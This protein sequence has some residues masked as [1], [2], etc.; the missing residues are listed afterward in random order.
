M[1][2]TA[3]EPDVNVDVETNNDEDDDVDVNPTGSDGDDDD[4]DKESSEDEDNKDRETAACNG[5]TTSSSRK[6]KR[7]NFKPR[8][9][10][11]NVDDHNDDEGATPASPAP[12]DLSKTMEGEEGKPL[13]VVRPEVL[14]GHDSSSPVSSPRPPSPPAAQP[15]PV[16]NP[17][18]AMAAGLLPFFN[19]AGVGGGADA[20]Q[21][22]M[23]DAFQ[24]VLKLYGVPSELA[25]AIAK[26]AQAAQGKTPNY[27]KISLIFI[28]SFSTKQRA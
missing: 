9:I 27:L 5:S 8:N 25:E 11:V 23:K 3:A 7:K 19:P 24:E 6:N 14:F 22:T 18:L 28:A 16:P 4:D 21:N 1:D 12:M 15:A 10:Q 17:G 26:N 2:E 20:A 13:S